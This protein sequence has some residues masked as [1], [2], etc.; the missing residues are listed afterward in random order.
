MLRNCPFFECL[1]QSAL[2]EV[3]G[4]AH[5]HTYQPGQIIILQGSLCTSAYFIGKGWVR[6]SIVSL[7]GR[8]QVMIRLGPGD[9]FCLVAAL[10][11][12]P[13]PATIQA[14][15]DVTVYAL[16]KEYLV[17][18][19]EQHPAIALAVIEN[20]AA[21]VRHFSSLV[22]DLSLRSVEARL[23]KLLLRLA[24]EHELAHPRMTRKEMAAELGTVREVVART[25]RRL[26]REDII[27]FDRHR[28]MILDRAA[29][30]EKTWV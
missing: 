27:R 13:N 9:A 24:Q 2:V 16:R 5:K 30:E 18:I 6:A 3:S 8:E 29:L 15:T 22:E 12:G 10:D 4:L 20:L 25:L 7:D 11:N 19:M 28:I 1:D 26:E 23:A 21:K 14:T 17:R